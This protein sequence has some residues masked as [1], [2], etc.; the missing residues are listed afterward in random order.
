VG[1]KPSSGLCC[2]PAC[3]GQGGSPS[4]H[5][6]S[7]WTRPVAMSLTIERLTL[8]FLA[9]TGC[10][11]PADMSALM[12]AAFFGDIFVI[13]NQSPVS[14]GACPLL[15]GSGWPFA[16]SFGVRLS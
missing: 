10:V 5:G 4:G 1:S 3:F 8:C 12:D 7:L 14:L 13:I 11:L 15:L 6:T 9:I 16:C 2:P